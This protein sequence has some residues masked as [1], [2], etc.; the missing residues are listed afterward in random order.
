MRK[1]TNNIAISINAIHKHYGSVHA[2]KGVDLEIKRGEF[3]GLLGKNGAGKSTLIN[4][5]AGL[6][7][8]DQGSISVLGHDV[9]TDYRAARKCLGVVP[10]ELVFDPF[11]TVREFL[12]IQAGYFGCG[13]EAH[14]WIDALIDKLALADKANTNMRAL[15]GGMKRRALIA[16]ALAHQPDVIV[17]D[18]PT[19]GVDVE[20]RALLWDFIRTL[21]KDGKT[22]VL[23]T[24]YLEEAES[25]CERIA[26]LDEGKVVA[27]DS[28]KKLM[29]QGIGNT[30]HLF[31]STAQP[32]AT[33]PSSLRDKVVNHQ[34]DQL[35]LRLHKDRDSVVAVIDLLRAEGADIVSLKTEHADLEDVFIELTRRQTG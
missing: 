33:V 19:A 22:I 25:L 24:H 15:S 21:H 9:I 6:S 14:D 26:I 32:L 4:I 13:K 23:T 34:A 2:L 27:C 16:Q 1:A 30:L 3:F 8:A 28:K 29:M 31:V 11:F 7:H 35:E 20:L 12:R 5:I 18:E 17:L 10:Q